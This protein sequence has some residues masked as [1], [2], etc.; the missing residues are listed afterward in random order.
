MR[1]AYKAIYRE[2]LTLE[3]ARARLEREAESEPVLAPLVAFLSVAGRG[4]VR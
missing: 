3:D 2:G 4:I 1:R